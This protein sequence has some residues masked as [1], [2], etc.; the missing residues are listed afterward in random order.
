MWKSWEGAG[1]LLEQKLCY[2]LETVKCYCCKVSWPVRESSR[3][4]QTLN[5]NPQL[6]MID[7]VGP[8]ACHS[9]VP[10][11]RSRRITEDSVVRFR[12]EECHQ[13]Q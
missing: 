3:R 8:H 11:F 12:P 5:M 6:S 4:S 10:A 7:S 13:T 9:R 1:L 2:L